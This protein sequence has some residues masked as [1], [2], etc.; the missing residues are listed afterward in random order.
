MAAEDLVGVGRV[1][2]GPAD[3]LAGDEAKLP[4]EALRDELLVKAGGQLRHGPTVLPSLRAIS[5]PTDE[6][7][8]AIEVVQKSRRLSVRLQN[9]IPDG[10]DAD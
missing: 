1:E 6:Q 3:P 10:A 8:E 7:A 4:L 5:D 2:V 9:L